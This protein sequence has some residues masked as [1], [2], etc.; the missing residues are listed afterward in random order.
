MLCSDA[1]E[2]SLRER[3]HLALGDVLVDT[4]LERSIAIVDGDFLAVRSSSCGVLC[5]RSHYRIDVLC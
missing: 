3:N 1:Q 2:D 4:R 5:V